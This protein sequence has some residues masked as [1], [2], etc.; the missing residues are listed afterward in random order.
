MYHMWFNFVWS[1]LVVHGTR[2]YINYSCELSVTLCSRD[3]IWSEP[4][5]VTPH[6]ISMIILPF[7]WLICDIFATS[8][9]GWIAIYLQF[10]TICISYCPLPSPVTVLIPFT[11]IGNDQEKKLPFVLLANI[12]LFN[13][14][15]TQEVAVV[16][17][18]LNSLY[19][20]TWL[21]KWPIYWQWFVPP[22]SW[23]AVLRKSWSVCSLGVLGGG[24]GG[25][26]NLA[27]VPRNSWL[28]FPRKFW[29]GWPKKSHV[30]TYLRRLSIL[31][32]F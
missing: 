14:R 12:V 31:K 26:G 2:A 1:R 20:S 22:S 24:G 23:R 10:C 8:K 17:K 16:F 4:R 25:A 27:D 19:T 30:Y 3:V 9:P 28:G 7:L 21:G 5:Y 13:I 32:F 11:H 18:Y 6:H 29:L 15:M